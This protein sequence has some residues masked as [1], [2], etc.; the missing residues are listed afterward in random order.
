MSVLALAGGITFYSLMYRRGRTMVRAPLLWRFD[1]KRAFDIV[2]VA[3][4]RTAGTLSRKLFP[5]RLQVQLLLIVVSAVAAGFWP[6]QS[7]DWLD[8]RLPLTPLD[9]LFAL[10]W[11]GGAAC[12]VGAALQAKFHRLAALTLL[13][14]AGLFTCLTFAWFSAPDL[15][16][17]QIVVETVTI[18]LFL[19]GLRWLPRRVDLAGARRTSLR[20]RARRTRDATLA[21]AAGAG[22]ATLAFAVVTRPASQ[23]LA[24]FFVE[25]ALQAAGGRNIV[26]VI[27]VDFRGFD[28][29][30]EITVVGI[31]A[32]IVYGLLRRFRPAPDSIAVPR[33]QR[34]AAESFG[35]RPDAALPDNYM[36]TPT[37]LARLV[38]PMAGLVSL[39]FL[40]RGHNAPGGGFVGGLV[41][42][43]AVI[44]HYM[45]SGTIWV[46]ARL[47]L[48]PQVWIGL[49]LLAAAAAGLGAWLAA[50]PFLTSISAD[51]H[52]PVLGE[53]HLSTVLLF[54]VGVY[55]L[56]V[57]AAILILIALAH[58]SLRSPRSVAVRTVEEPQPA[59][60]DGAAL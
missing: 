30:G 32:L 40:L 58:Q 13:G 6:L 52:V 59:A 47:K 38:L 41:M 28:T 33:A 39:Y 14:G 31:V 9:P 37:V 29:L 53:V 18:V 3:V 5:S 4:T 24:P 34:D 26:N 60:T 8:G 44:V 48:V 50:Q 11:V 15:A 36:R 42:A 45:M 12:A 22:L 17:T 35:S 54:D 1:S 57:G 21:V 51:I 43:T 25:N 56:V 7:R 55:M 16:L 27:L 49:G 19:L 23:V 46:E 2:N 20:A 10:L